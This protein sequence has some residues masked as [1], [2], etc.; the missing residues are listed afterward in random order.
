MSVSSILIQ[1]SILII[2]QQIT[3]LI[4]SLLKNETLIKFFVL[5]PKAHIVWCYDL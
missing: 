4:G 2:T 5:F 1:T 3:I